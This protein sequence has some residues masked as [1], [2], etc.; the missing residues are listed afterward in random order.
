M[1]STLRARWVTPQRYYLRY[2]ARTFTH[3]CCRDHAA[4]NA[5]ID[6]CVAL[7]EEKSAVLWKVL[8]TA[9]RGCV[10][11]LIGKASDAVQTIGAGITGVSVNGGNSIDYVVF[12][13][14]GFGLCGPRKIR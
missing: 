7:A 2:P 11:A 9:Q 12:I 14:F 8:A 6:E 1:R 3:I 4:A 5:Q 13:I 10:L